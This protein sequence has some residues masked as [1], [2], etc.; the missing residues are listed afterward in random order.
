MTLPDGSHPIC[1]CFCLLPR[2]HAA[3]DEVIVA[4]GDGLLDSP[5]SFVVVVNYRA[6]SVLQVRN[7]LF[8]WHA[9]PLL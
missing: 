4:A 6:R 5:M 1:L 3:V 9:E 8:N 2:T 7:L